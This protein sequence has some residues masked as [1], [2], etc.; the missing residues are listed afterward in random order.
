MNLQCFE[1]VVV[2][3]PV[4]HGNSVY[5][6]ISCKDTEGKTHSFNLRFKYEEQLS[7]E[8]LALLRI[9]AVMP[10]LNYGLFT[11]Q[12]RLDF[13]VSRADFS[14][15]NDLLGIFTKDIFINKLVR[16]KNPYVL[17]EFLPTK[18]E[19]LE[20]N[21]CP[22]AKIIAL[23]L[24]EDAPLS[25]EL[26]EESCGVLSS[27]GK[28]S[29]LTYAMLKEIGA[30]VHPLY[31]NES[32]GHW[33]TALPAYRYFKDHYTNTT[34]VWTNVDRFYTFMLD[35]MRIIR[36]DHRKIWADT[37]PIRL[38]I[39]PFYIFLL[40]PIFVE[41]RIGNILLGSEFDDPRLSPFYEGIRHF[42]GVYDQTQDYDVR[43]EQWFSKRIPGMCQWSAVRS[44]SGLIVERILTK[45][46]PELACLQRSCHSCH[47]EHGALIPCGKCSKCQGVLLF[48]LAN[49]V[50]PSIIGYTKT[51]VEALPARITQGGLRIDEDEKN[52]A[53]FLA[54][55][56]PSSDDN[57]IRH[58][59][60]VH[61][62]K[63][64]SDLQLLPKCFRTPILRILM[65]YT[66]GFSKLKGNKWIGASLPSEL[67]KEL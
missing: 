40:L 35:H 33:R 9:A 12:I 2:S 20:E 23:N 36:K 8:Q 46:Y 52:R 55:L 17:S 1:S 41:R 38:S 26:K 37:Y 7:Q 51:D 49:Q 18:S 66:E 22:M 4:V 24:V 60:T 47:F 42:F 34:R 28:E 39:F 5:T 25:S 58:I 29:L 67:A 64:N 50:D 16:N 32:G 11:K 31:V 63:P 21:A 48:L 43:M 10:L 61:L 53:L 45:R 56:V 14:L 6:K 54:K 44:I 19:V 62:H 13:Q 65:E 27:G 59:E 15:L 57:E 3:D 30:E